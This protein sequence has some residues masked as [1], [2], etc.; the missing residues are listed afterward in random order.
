[1]PLIV[2]GRTRPVHLRIACLWRTVVVGEG[3]HVLPEIIEWPLEHK[4]LHAPRIKT[5]TPCP[6][7]TG[8]SAPLPLH[9]SDKQA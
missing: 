9:D 4:I 7:L 1:V 5:W 2:A 3:D 8:H 6:F